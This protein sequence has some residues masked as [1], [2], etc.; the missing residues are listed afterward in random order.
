MMTKTSNEGSTRALC[1]EHGLP[2]FYA[3][4]S[5]FCEG[6]STTQH[7]AT[8]PNPCDLSWSDLREEVGEVVEVREG[9]EIFAAE[10]WVTDLTG[11]SASG[12]SRGYAHTAY[13]IAY[14]ENVR[15]VPTLDDMPGWVR[16][17]FSEAVRTAFVQGWER[18]VVEAESDEAAL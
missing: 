3:A 1:G 5:V 16:H 14:G 11:P 12:E 8:D 13:K 7:P 17:H 15:A 6:P 9:D 18:G 2:L 10:V 4:G